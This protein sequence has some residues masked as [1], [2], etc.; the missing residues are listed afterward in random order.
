L[1]RTRRKRIGIINSARGAPLNITLCGTERG[2]IRRAVARSAK[3]C[4]SRLLL[5]F[6]INGH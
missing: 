4:R 2:G 3:S 5:S 6:L 1:E